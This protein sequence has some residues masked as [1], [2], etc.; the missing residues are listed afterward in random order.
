MSKYLMDILDELTKKVD[1]IAKT[2]QNEVVDPMSEFFENQT[3]TNKML[4]R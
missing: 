1:S 3:L 2:I 4:L